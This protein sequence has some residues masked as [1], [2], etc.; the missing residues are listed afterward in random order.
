[1]ELNLT[2]AEAKKILL[3]WAQA[4]FGDLFNCV[5]KEGYSY[6]ETFVFTKVETDNDSL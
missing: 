1:M 6:S 4:K 3:D 5:S 2:T